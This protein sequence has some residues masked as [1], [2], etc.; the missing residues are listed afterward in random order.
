MAWTVASRSVTTPLRIPVEGASPT[1]MISSPSGPDAA[2]TAHVF[3]VP[4]SRPAMVSPLAITSSPSLAPHYIVVRRGIT[5][6]IIHMGPTD[7]IHGGCGELP[8]FDDRGP[9]R[10]QVDGLDRPLRPDSGPD[11][12]DQRGFALQIGVVAEAEG[13]P[14]DVDGLDP[15]PAVAAQAAH[16]EVGVLQR[17]DV[18]QEPGD[19]GVGDRPARRGDLGG[20]RVDVRGRR[21]GAAGLQ[22]ARGGVDGHFALA[23]AHARRGPPHGDRQLDEGLGELAAVHARAV[24][25]R[26][27]LD[28]AADRARVQQPDV[29][30]RRD[31]GGAAHLLARDRRGERDVD[32]DVRDAEP[33][34][35]HEPRAAPAGQPGEQHEEDPERFDPRDHRRLPAPR[36]R[37]SVGPHAPLRAGCGASTY[38]SIASATPSCATSATTWSA[39]ASSSGGPEPIATP[40]AAASSS[41][42]S[43]HASPTASVSSSATPCRC[44]TNASASPLFTAGSTT[45]TKSTWLRVRYARAPSSSRSAARCASA[46]SASSTSTILIVG[47]SA[48]A[49]RSDGTTTGSTRA[50][51]V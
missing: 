31:R 20:A 8:E 14:G 23:G 9:R 33:R 30:A 17:L 34:R 1:P 11:G 29:R 36:Q 50:R 6:H 7:S 38:R 32:P 37:P 18:A 24:D 42:T 22:D 49:S 4:M 39:C 44:A 43:F 51:S 47:R 21:G 15:A 19:L 13:H 25:V 16:G 35:L 12:L 28:A 27:R 10:T 5:Y 40:T 3:V 48:N 45:S 26:D 41:G 46:R 2:T